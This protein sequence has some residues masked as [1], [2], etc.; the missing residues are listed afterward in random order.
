MARGSCYWCSGGLER[1]RNM[2]VELYYKDIPSTC[3]EQGSIFC[4]S[5][6][7]LFFNIA[8]DEDGEGEVGSKEEGG[9]D[10]GKGCTDELLGT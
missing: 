7:A 1:S 9:S 5:Q 4:S 2:Q 3:Q 10:H 8:G 6:D